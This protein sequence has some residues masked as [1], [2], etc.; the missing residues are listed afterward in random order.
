MS[1]YYYGNIK[2]IF[3][4]A[5]LYRESFLQDN[6]YFSL[7]QLCDSYDLLIAFYSV[8]WKA[9][10]TAKKQFHRCLVWLLFYS[11]NCAVNSH[12]NCIPWVDM[13]TV[14]PNLYI[15]FLSIFLLHYKNTFLSTELCW[16]LST[17]I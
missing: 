6:L 9:R 11:I 7:V 16:C 5:K 4:L 17:A 15:L 2:F 10:W 1:Q 3:P 8:F 14:I 12:N 13:I